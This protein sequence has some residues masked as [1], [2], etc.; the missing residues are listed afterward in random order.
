MKWN[1]MLSGLI[2][3]LTIT[4]LVAVPNGPIDNAEAVSMIDP[5]F[6]IQLDHDK[7]YTDVHPGSDGIVKVTG[8]VT[9]SS[10][11]NDVQSYS[12][13]LVVDGGGWPTSAPERMT[14]S[15]EKTT[16]P[17]EASIQVPIETSSRITGQLTISGRWSPDSD[18]IGGIIE[19]KTAAI[20]ANKYYDL[21]V[22]LEERHANA[23]IGD[24]H[25]FKCR[26]INQGNG[27][28]SVKV[29]I[30]NLIELTNM[31]WEVQL[32]QDKFQ[33]PEKQERILHISVM[34]GNFTSP[35]NYSIKLRFFSPEAEALET[36]SN[37]HEMNFTIEVY[38][39]N[40]SEVPN[41]GVAQLIAII[42][43]FSVLISLI[44]RRNR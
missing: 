18:G 41:I 1:P 12:V 7:Y 35:G 22:G 4:I 25:G 38:E 23:N 36:A 27:E 16:I 37:I 40:E 24:T 19:N 8:N 5:Y 31:S 13:I 39:V 10:S 15:E 3:L 21:A 17:F 2:S 30:V 43:L 42:I 9:V 29:E 20:F 32:S 6:S 44:R 14:F 34:V 33:I 28:D 26:L 11:W